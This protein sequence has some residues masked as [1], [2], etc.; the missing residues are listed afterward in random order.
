MKKLR[1]HRAM[2]NLVP[3]V[4]RALCSYC[5]VIHDI[6]REGYCNFNAEAPLG[7]KYNNPRYPVGISQTWPIDEY[8]TVSV[9][10]TFAGGVWSAV[11]W[12]VHVAAKTRWRELDEDQQSILRLRLE[13]AEEM[14]QAA[15]RA[16]GRRSLDLGG[17][18]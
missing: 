8:R 13:I 15:L 9:G 6:V 2:R 16:T 12:R 17:E 18:S 3:P 7:M 14:R 1:V 5:R 10:S 11:P 4:R